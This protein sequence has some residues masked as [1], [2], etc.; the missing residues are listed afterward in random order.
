MQRS[1][2]LSIDARTALFIL[3]CALALFAVRA[4][5][6]H[7]YASDLPF[8]DQW[9]AEG[10]HL[11][12]PLLE[13]R[14]DLTTLFAPHNEHRIFW[15]RLMSLVAFELNGQRWGN[16][17][18][19]YFSEII[20]AAVW[21]FV[22]ALVVRSAVSTWM[23]LTFT[24]VVL[25]L[26]AMPFDWENIVVGFQSQFYFL[27]AFCVTGLAVAAYRRVGSVT[28]IIC[29]T[30]A[31]A[32]L[33]TMASGLLVAPAIAVVFLTRAWQGEYSWR[34]ISP[35]VA[36]LF[37][38]MLIGWKLVPDIPGHASLKA[39][40]LGDFLNAS[41]QSLG[42]PA[43]L[44]WL[45]VA[46]IWLPAVLMILRRRDPR[47]RQ[48]IDRFMVG[49]TAFAA[50]QALAIALSRGHDMDGVASRYTSLL[51]LGL[52]ANIWFVLRLVRTDL[53][54][55]VGILSAIPLAIVGTAAIA[56]F[57]RSLPNDFSQAALR[58][59]MSCIQAA[60]VGS[61]LSRGD[62]QSLHQP[63]LQIPYP[64]AE[65]LATFLDDPTLSAALAGVPRTQPVTETHA[66]FRQRLAGVCLAS[67]SPDSK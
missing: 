37:I 38:V 26:A 5:L 9:D 48:P 20:F 49:L 8:W 4:V 32:S 45:G 35:T 12:K 22:V 19:A 59:R 25:S 7:R 31:V 11:L 36:M 47:L 46:V 30:I 33:F 15:T 55:A 65:R 41:R 1:R 64:S 14:L 44:G 56:G 40:S 3:L 60:N 18:A 2:K 67:V 29:A 13:A 39:N 21:T 16:L 53:A 57:V 10:D 23:K 61:Y 27:L 52:V 63:F 24:L 50:G 62:V 28:T 54:P 66:L 43:N 58:H 17:L 51:A 42:W 34:S 6:V